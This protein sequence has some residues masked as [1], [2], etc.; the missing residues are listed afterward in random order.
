[1]TAFANERESDPRNEEEGV[2]LP[3]KWQNLGSFFGYNLLDCIRQETL[4]SCSLHFCVVAR[5]IAEIAS[6]DRTE[7]TGKKSR[8]GFSWRSLLKS[9]SESSWGSLLV[10]VTWMILRSF[11]SSTTSLFGRSTTRLF[12]PEWTDCFCRERIHIDSHSTSCNLHVWLWADLIL[13]DV[14]GHL[15][16]SCILRMQSANG[17][18]L[19]QLELPSISSLTRLGG[20]ETCFQDYLLH[21]LNSWFKEFEKLPSRMWGPET[22]MTTVEN[23]L[24]SLL[25]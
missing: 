14:T 13:L 18:I 3:V 19:I 23:Q 8:S 16:M 24:E 15:R 22:W 7:Q 6:L 2:T 10:P 9:R 1:M 5:L 25:Q 11:L 21:N 17:K 20:R 4:T 12:I